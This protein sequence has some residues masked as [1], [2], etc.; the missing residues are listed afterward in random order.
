MDL[1][2]GKSVLEP[3][4]K[5]KTGPGGQQVPFLGIGQFCEL[6]KNLKYQLIL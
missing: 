4:G 2:S 1:V 6:W 3:V 5:E